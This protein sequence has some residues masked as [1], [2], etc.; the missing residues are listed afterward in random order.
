[1]IMLMNVDGI[2]IVIIQNC[3]LDLL[4]ITEIKNTDQGKGMENTCTQETVLV[5]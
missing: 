2:L 3:V 5:L 1:M 4:T